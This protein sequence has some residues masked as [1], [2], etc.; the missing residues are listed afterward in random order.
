MTVESSTAPAVR[1]DDPNSLSRYLLSFRWP[2]RDDAVSRHLVRGGLPLWRQILAS[3]PTLRNAGAHWS[4]GA[5][6]STS[7]C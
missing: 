7:P 5:P 6:R 3:S 4:L 2:Y 1:E